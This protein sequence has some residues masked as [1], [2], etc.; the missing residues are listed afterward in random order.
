MKRKVIQFGD[1]L[2]K[3][4]PFPP[5]EEEDDWG[6]SVENQVLELQHVDGA[7]RAMGYSQSR[8]PS[9]VI[10]KR[11]VVRG[12][13][14]PKI[15]GLTSGCRV[16]KSYNMRQLIDHVYR[17]L[18]G[19]KFPG[20]GGVKRLYAM[21]EDGTIRYTLAE[22]ISIPYSTGF[23]E[24]NGWQAFTV[25]FLMHDP[26]WYDVDDG[27]TFYKPLYELKDILSPCQV[28]PS[29]DFA[30]PIYKTTHLCRDDCGG[31]GL[32]AR[33]PAYNGYVG[34]GNECSYPECAIDPCAYYLGDFYPLPSGDGTFSIC[35]VG[36]AGARRPLVSLRNAFE[37]PT[38]TNLENGNMISYNGVIADGEY[39]E[40][41]LGS[42]LNGEVEDMD[43]NTNIPGFSRDNL[44][45]NNEGFFDL[46]IGTNSILVMGATS[47]NAMFTLK[48][49]NKWHN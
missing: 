35:V 46:L 16:P 19:D 40:I 42:A 34:I 20:S 13:S 5:F 30:N 22:A 1:E 49:I 26:Y 18:R 7:F 47:T 6:D 41:D 21:M 39:I 33:D 12:S 27:F 3:L 25:D 2:G 37:N 32:I 28:F 14:I 31:I 4:F 29:G 11:F 44:T 43:I 23:S 8:K 24:P 10:T 36:S 38:I 17:T 45:I 15:A 9:K 48:L